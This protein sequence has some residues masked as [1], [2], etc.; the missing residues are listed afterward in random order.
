M[1]HNIVMTT[2]RRPTPLAARARSLFN[3]I[4]APV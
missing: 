1:V 3:R 4:A 2:E